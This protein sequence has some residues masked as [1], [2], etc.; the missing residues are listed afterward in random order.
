MN[1]EQVE[2]YYEQVQSILVAR[3]I[4]M[5]LV[6]HGTIAGRKTSAPGAAWEKATVAPN[7]PTGENS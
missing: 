5:K 3:V 1:L 6:T 2:E 7:P 4:E